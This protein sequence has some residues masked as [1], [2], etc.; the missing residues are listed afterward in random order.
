M[1]YI[2]NPQC[3]F[4]VKYSQSKD[5]KNIINIIPETV[6][7]LENEKL[8]NSLQEGNYIDYLSSDSKWECGMIVQ[9]GPYRTQIEVINV[10]TEIKQWI[11]VD[12]SKIAVF[13]TKFGSNSE[14]VATMKIDDDEHK[15]I[16]QDDNIDPSL[17]I[18]NVEWKDSLCVGDLVDAMDSYNTWYQAV[19]LEVYQMKSLKR[20]REEGNCFYVFL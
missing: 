16:I 18:D 6:A 19:I 2:F 8:A 14:E 11:N 7:Q 9:I 10:N 12:N 13:G 20:V 17:Q 5:P 15:D 3:N 4:Y 1:T